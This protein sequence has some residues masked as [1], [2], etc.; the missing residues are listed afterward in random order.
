[1]GIV[2]VQGDL[3]ENL[4]V[5]PSQQN[6]G[7]GT[8]LLNFA[9]GQCANAPRLWILNTNQGA[10]RFYERN[11]FRPT[12]NVLHHSGGIYELEMSKP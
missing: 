11:G 8:Q 2:S 3:I 1:M 7:Y 6:K 9:Q 12:G 10:K 4:Y 5:L